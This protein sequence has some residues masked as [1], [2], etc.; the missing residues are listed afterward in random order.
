LQC[1]AGSQCPVSAEI[2]IKNVAWCDAYVMIIANTW[3]FYCW[4]FCKRFLGVGAKK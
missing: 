2:R 3:Y 4:S 1:P